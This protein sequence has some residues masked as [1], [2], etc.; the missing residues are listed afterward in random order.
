MRFFCFRFVAAVAIVAA[1]GF[2]GCSK[3]P[4]P[5][6]QER[7][8]YVF[9]PIRLAA[10]Y[11]TLMEKPDAVRALLIGE[12]A[13]QLKDVFERVGV[14]ALTTREGG[15]YDIILVA[16]DEM[17]PA[18]YA[19]AAEMLTENG[20]I[21][22][23]MDVR[24]VTFEQFRHRLEAFL[25]EQVHLWMPGDGHWL[26]VGR[27][28]PRQVK[29]SAMLDVFT[30]EGAFDDFAKAISA[31]VPEM[32]ASYVGTRE[33]VVPVFQFNDA[34]AAVC[35][36]C[37]VTK[38]IPTLD[39]VSDVGLDAD[40]AQHLRAE[41]R[42]MQVV[43]RLVLEGKLLSQKATDK[44]SEAP[45]IE[46]W[47][48]AALRNPHDLM[49]HERLDRLDRNAR[50]FLSLGKILQAMKCYET[51]ILIKPTAASVHNF[52]KCLEKIGKRELAEQA[53]KRARELQGQ[54]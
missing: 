53:F 19:K 38:D 39:W 3:S 1:L 31:T 4:E 10:A 9:E 27:S 46:K 7:D 5:E 28:N 30:R 29:L 20:V 48:T 50:G 16:C 42:S 8:P 21:A 35:P 45:A 43:R 33:D 25:P 24:G 26:L 22:W 44:K 23:M 54:Q 41:I 12:E 17:S 2:G 36:E 15:R 52:G 14:K 37:F 34:K 18:S 51:M 49:L 6:A 32:F 11:L 13:R 40:I 47:N